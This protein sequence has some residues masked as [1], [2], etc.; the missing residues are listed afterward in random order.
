MN[1][2]K[3]GTII[4]LNAAV[5]NLNVWRTVLT[6]CMRDKNMEN[7]PLDWLMTIVSP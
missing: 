5:T 4:K 1:F 7:I 6:H 3:G 2:K